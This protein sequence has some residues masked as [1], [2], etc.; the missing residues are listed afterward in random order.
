[1]KT[2]LADQQQD[3]PLTTWRSGPFSCRW[4][5]QRCPESADVD[6][7]SQDSLAVREDGTRLAFT[8]CDGVSQSFYGGLA[9]S[10]LGSGLLDWLWQQPGS[11][12]NLPDRLDLFLN[13]LTQQATRMVRAQVLP[14]DLP[15]LVAS[16]LERKRTLGSESMFIAG[17]VDV[18]Q[19]Q[20]F[21]AWAGD[22][23]LRAWKDGVE[24]T[25]PFY[26][27]FR[28]A[29]RWSSSRGLVVAWHYALLNCSEITHIAAYSD[30]LAVLDGVPCLPEL[31]SAGLEERLRSAI[32]DDSS[33]F[34]M[35]FL[36]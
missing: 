23:R 3:T 18:P 16:V 25:D 27:Y 29:D 36:N 34:E 8:L 12:D 14:A 4:A 19:D 7:P 15:A 30:G 5:F 13:S 9:A 2:F 17:L 6:E 20:V 35:Q 32:E 33:Y 26:G 31:E 24:I 28:T 21:L 1:M 10:V 11:L 22:S